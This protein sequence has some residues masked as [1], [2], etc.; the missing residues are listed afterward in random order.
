MFFTN[1][2]HIAEY[3]LSIPYSLLT[4]DNLRGHDGLQVTIKCFNVY[5]NP[6][7]IMAQTF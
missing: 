7:L 5:G 3:K 1:D 4:A 2:Y 6:H